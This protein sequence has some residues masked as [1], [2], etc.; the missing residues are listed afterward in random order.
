M[1]AQGVKR[2]LEGSTV[3][4]ESSDAKRQVVL[5]TKEVIKKQI[6]YYMSDKNL[7]MDALFHKEISAHADGFLAMERIFGCNKVK[8]MK[9]ENGESVIEADVVSA[10]VD[11]NEVEYKEGSGIRRKDNKPLP[12]FE[13]RPGKQNSK[14]SPKSAHED[15]VV[16][17]VEKVDTPFL[18]TDVKTALKNILVKD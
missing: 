12:A 5:A 1:S 3:E 10:L 11:S 16:L 14:K 17:M 13:G 15:G 6:E 18:W 8:T 9:K 2:A 4:Q 7:K